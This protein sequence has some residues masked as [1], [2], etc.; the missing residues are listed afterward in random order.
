MQIL[1]PDNEEAVFRSVVRH[2]LIPVSDTVQIW[3]SIIFS[4]AI[5]ERVA[6]V[7]NST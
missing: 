1:I 2:A 4:K 5:A 7:L 6:E 3:P